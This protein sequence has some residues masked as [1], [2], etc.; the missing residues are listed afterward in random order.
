MLV[1]HFLAAK[2]A[3]KDLSEGRI[4]CSVFDDVNDRHEL[5]A[6]GLVGFEDKTEHFITFLTDK[7][8]LI[9]CGWDSADQHMWSKYGDEG[10]GICLGLEIEAIYQ[11]EYVGAKK[12]C[13]IPKE[14]VKA[15]TQTGQLHSNV[16]S[17]ADEQIMPYIRPFLF[18]KFERTEFGNWKKEK[19]WRAIALKRQDEDGLFYDNFSNDMY[20]KEVILGHDC[21]T[22]EDAVQSIVALYPR[23]P[24][25]VRKMPRIRT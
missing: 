18:T 11:V 22:P 6:Y 9:C 15:A 2:W 5:R 16:V 12:M 19:E 4:K 25:T 10:R 1:F 23:Q 17:P 20:L 7:F 8:V 13:S 24:I 14:I 21:D 3:L